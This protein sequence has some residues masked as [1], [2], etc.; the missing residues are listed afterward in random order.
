V[1]APDGAAKLEAFQ[2]QAVLHKQEPLGKW[3][4]GKSRVGYHCKLAL[5][6]RARES[7][8]MSGALEVQEQQA[9]SEAKGPRGALARDCVQCCRGRQI[10]FWRALLAHSGG[11][12]PFLPEAAGHEGP[13][14]WCRSSRPKGLEELG[15][16]V[17]LS[18]AEEGKERAGSSASV[19]WGKIPSLSQSWCSALP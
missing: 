2:A 19:R 17:V 4:Q 8:G 11:K 16:A 1:A 3:S 14:W 15:Q 18:A 5:A 6:Q 7:Q 13:S 10:T 9:R 12:K